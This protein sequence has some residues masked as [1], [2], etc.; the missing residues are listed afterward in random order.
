[1]RRI[2]IG[3]LIGLGIAI[4]CAVVSAWHFYEASQ[5]E[6]E[7]RR[8]F[9]ARPMEIA[10]DLSK[11]GEIAAPFHQ[12]CSIS[13]GEALYLQCDRP[14]SSEGDSGGLFEGL[15][16]KVVVRDPA[17]ADVETIAIDGKTIQRLYGAVVLAHFSPFREGDFIATL[18]VE[19][20]A[21]RLAGR[22]QVVYAKYLLCGMERMPAVIA[23]AIAY[24]AGIIGLVATACILPGLWRT[25]IWQK[26]VTQDA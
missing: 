18:R 24:G 10:V 25:G 4:V 7:F 19:S 14:R 26:G 23:T 13:H 8:W 1:M 6:A 16:A 5:R 12:T 21:P 15:V 22:R 17:G 3:R 2:A 11:P 20:G 9:D